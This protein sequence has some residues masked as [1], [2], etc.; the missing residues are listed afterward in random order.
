MEAGGLFRGY[1]NG[2]ALRVEGLLLVMVC[3]NNKKELDI[4]MVKI[5]LC[6]KKLDASNQLE[7]F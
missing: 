2:R 5:K 4:V 1:I 6:P 3:R 7:V